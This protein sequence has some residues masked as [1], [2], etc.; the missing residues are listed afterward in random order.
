MPGVAA[1]AAAEAVQAPAARGSGATCAPAN[2]ARRNHYLPLPRRRFRWPPRKFPLRPLCRHQAGTA[3]RARTRA[4]AGSRHQLGAVHGREAAGLDWRAGGVPRRGLLRQILV[5]QQSDLARGADGARL[6]RRAGFAGGRRGHVPEG[7][8]RARAYVVRH[9]R[10][11][12]LRGHVCLPRDLPFRVLRTD[13][14]L[15]A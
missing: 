9:R 13:P 12:P 10:G 1:A 15:P 2:P 8:C 7:V 6:Y 11:D 5:R 4:Q 14:H 3:A